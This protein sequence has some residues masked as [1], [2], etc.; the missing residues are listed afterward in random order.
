M[1]TAGGDTCGSRLAVR[2]HVPRNA[3]GGDLGM[4]AQKIEGIGR[5]RRI[6]ALRSVESGLF[7]GLGLHPLATIKNGEIV[8]RGQVVGIDRL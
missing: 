4:L 6:D 1:L 3:F 7:R 5:S 2:V 8:M